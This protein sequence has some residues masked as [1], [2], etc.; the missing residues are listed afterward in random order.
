MSTMPVYF[1]S[2]GGGPW[3]YVETMRQMFAKTER[4]LKA[5]PGRLPM[6]PTA[7]LVI[8][9]HWE[10]EAFTVSTAEHPPMMYDYSGFPEHTYH[11]RY[12]APG[13]PSLAARVKDLLSNADWSVR[14]DPYRGFDHGTFVP[15]ALM[16]P[17]ADVP[18]AMLSIKSSYDP[19]EH[20]RVGQALS[21]LR[22]EGVLIIGSGMTYHNMRGFGRD[23]STG[24][25]ETFQSFL[26]SAISQPDWRVRNEML[27]HWENAAGA[28]LAHPRED[29]LIP[30]MVVAGA[31][32]EDS[33]REAFVDRVFNVPTASYEFGG[34]RVET[35]A[36]PAG[37]KATDDHV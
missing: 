36:G 23:E 6:K 26:G 4:A 29:H 20:I 30:L 7:V 15:L 37:C 5:L 18:V 35:A 1:L 14:E 16:Y 25:A 27:T 13:S 33:G 2:H 31:A 3:P 19:E 12:P 17:D 21:S 10:A 28:R 9:G 8:T 22:D 34:G 32:A 24:I 11:I